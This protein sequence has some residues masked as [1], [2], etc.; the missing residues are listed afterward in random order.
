MLK[1][2]SS[3]ILCIICLIIFL[4]I[5]FVVLWE[6]YTSHK[7]EKE[8]AT[9]GYIV[10]KGYMGKIVSEED[11]QKAVNQEWIKSSTETGGYYQYINTSPASWQ[12]WI[13]YPEINKELKNVKYNLD[14][15]VDD[16]AKQRDIIRIYLDEKEATSDE[17]V[18][19][20]LALY[21]YAPSRAGHPSEI[22][23]YVNG[24]KAKCIGYEAA[25]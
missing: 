8:A 10:V 9:K 25:L 13:Y 11:Y 7:I 21:I 14:F 4:L 18:M 20:D 5:A 3:L 6:V 23:V 15:K 1:K 17:E 24:N 22:E 12:I 16:Y 19:K 2:L